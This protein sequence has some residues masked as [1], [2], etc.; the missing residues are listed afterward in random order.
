MKPLGIERKTRIRPLLAAVL[1][2]G[3]GSLAGPAQAQ[4]TDDVVTL[5][6]LHVQAAPDQPG[7]IASPKFTAPLLD[8]PQTVQ[9]I[10]NE[11]FT[12]QG[13]RSLTD[14]LRNTP[15]ISFN[16]GENGFA[17]ST[18]NFTLR[19]FDTSGNIF[20]DGTRDSGNYRRDV[21]NV[22]QVEVVKG[23]A[24]DN[25]RGGG[26]GYVNIVTK[27]PHLRDS[28]TAS[29]G[30]GLDEYD[31]EHRL[32][33]TLDVNRIIGDGT[34]VRVNVL[35]QEGGVAGRQMAEHNSLGVA[36]SLA[37]G[38]DGPT[39]LVLAYQ[40]LEQNDLPDWGIPA[41]FIED[42]VRFDPTLDEDDR[43]GF[44]GLAS[45]YDDTRS[46]SALARIEHDFSQNLRLSNQTRWV[47]TA[48]DARYTLPT[49]YAPATREV[50]TQTQFYDRENISISNLTNLT[51]RFDTGGLRHT[52][53]AGLEVMREKS[54]ALRFGTSNQPVTDISSPDP[55]RTGAPNVAA[56]EVSE[57]TIDTIALY[58]YDTVE[59]NER[60]EL[61]GGLRGERYEV[62][63][64]SRTVAGDPQGPDQ[65]DVS[66]TTLTGKLGLV[67]KP[68]EN[69]SIYGAVSMSAL[70]PGSYLSNPDIS[71]TG[72]NAFPGL[73]GQNNE[74]ARTQKALNYE[75][76]LKW[77][78][79]DNRLNASAALF[80]TERR[81]VAIT[82]ADNPGDPVTLQGYGKQIVQGLE[83]SLAG[84]IREG[85]NAWGGIL[86]LD[87]ERR[88]SAELDEKRRNANP[89]DFSGDF[90]TF[91][92]TRGD[93][94]AFTPDVTASIWTSYAF[95]SGVTVGGGI[96]YVADSWI[97]R[98]D[99]ADRILPNG[100][101]GKLPGYAVLNLMASYSVSDNLLLR[102]NIDNVTDELYA[103]S[104][105][106]AAQRVFTGAPRSYLLTADL[107]F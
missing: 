45:D 46:H 82:G 79:F 19:G 6:S 14:V 13:A 31:S 52:A 105:N 60:W 22:E 30:Y 55:F 5:R 68:V 57:V 84:E 89:G 80:R 37:F 4:E 78:F 94:L 104:S 48:R 50:N 107:R 33:S 25:G 29:I 49:G 98:P 72:D 12:Q 76:G 91:T 103:V 34:A 20:V 51:F 100:L 73:A 106:W 96:Q 32:R 17:T 15:G 21:F 61:T 65:Y 77:N 85:W 28:Q 38:L 56:S 63:I 83:L 81:N 54:D 43:D 74:E 69:G 99:D 41:A 87:S 11:L 93:E 36:P 47:K 62:D 102:L 3:C 92:S 7:Q 9:V 97:G 8:T 90:G 23:P 101:F 18:N 40:Y 70:P 86:F 64:A 75:L 53:A 2:A 88:H 66:D 95:T 10:P 59:L 16:A 39:R 42:M 67:F 27:T 58:A 44:F 71:R 26:G 1:C 24:A 35:M